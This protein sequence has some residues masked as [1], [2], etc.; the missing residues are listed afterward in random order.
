MNK[1]L[2]AISASAYLFLKTITS[3]SWHQTTTSRIELTTL[4]YMYLV[5]IDLMK[6]RRGISRTIFDDLLLEF[7]EGRGNGR[8]DD[9]GLE[10]RFLD[11]H[12]LM[13]IRVYWFE[14]SSLGRY[15]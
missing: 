9:S 15:G 6:F 11:R 10:A 14:N 1:R 13:L 12:K 5:F 8:D 3:I 7:V 2:F 4:P